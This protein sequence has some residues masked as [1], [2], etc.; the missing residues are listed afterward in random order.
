MSKSSLSLTPE[1]QSFKSSL[2]RQR[3]TVEGKNLGICTFAEIIEEMFR[4]RLEISLGVT[5]RG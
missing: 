4:I 2:T 1:F 5:E 3:I